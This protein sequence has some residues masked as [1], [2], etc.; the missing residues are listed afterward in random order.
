MLSTEEKWHS[1]VNAL[2]LF[3]C[4]WS[5][6]ALE[7]QLLPFLSNEVYVSECRVAMKIPYHPF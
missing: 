1:K 2:L 5:D 4:M 3:I 6:A 7:W